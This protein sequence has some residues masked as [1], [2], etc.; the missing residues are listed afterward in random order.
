MTGMPV[1][2]TIVSFGA[3]LALKWFVYERVFEIPPLSGDNLYI[4]SLVDHATPSALLRGDPNFYPEWR[5]LPTE[6][7]W[8]Q[9][10]WSNINGTGAYYLV[11]LLLWATVAWLVYYAVQ[12]A[13]NSAAAGLVAAAFVATDP[14]PV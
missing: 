9:Y 11:N 12:M 5:P 8:L 10:R 13:A 6:T 1:R 7:I 4:L 3:V 14:R 2:R